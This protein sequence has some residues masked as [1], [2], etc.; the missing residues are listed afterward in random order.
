MMTTTTFGTV[1]I[2][3]GRTTISADGR[4]LRDWARRGDNRWPCSHLATLDE[5]TVIY[6]SRGDL[7]DISGDER[8]DLSCD[9]LDAWASEV[10]QRAGYPNHPAIRH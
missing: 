2:E 1:T 8:A 3:P 10:L 7:V 4:T 5:V 9:E 6:D